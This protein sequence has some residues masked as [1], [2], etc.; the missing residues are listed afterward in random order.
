MVEPPKLEGEVWRGVD[1]M[2]EPV[3]VALR[4]GH[5]YA[6]WW[7]PEDGTWNPATQIQYAADI[8]SAWALAERTKAERA[9]RIAKLALDALPQ[10][11]VER[12]RRAILGG[13]P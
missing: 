4:E 2:D 7:D 9:R 6:W 11:Q 8:M 5:Y 10:E 13:Q 12:L 1:A 3:A